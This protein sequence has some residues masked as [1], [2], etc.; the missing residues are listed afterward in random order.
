MNPAQQHQKNQ[1]NRVQLDQYSNDVFLLKTSKPA[2][3]HNTITIRLKSLWAKVLR[4]LDMTETAG[5]CPPYSSS[6][7]QIRFQSCRWSE[8]SCR[9]LIA[10]LIHRLVPL[11]LV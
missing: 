3:A 5:L 4:S 2:V 7:L 11:S 6:Q 1:L 10:E 9:G 8:N